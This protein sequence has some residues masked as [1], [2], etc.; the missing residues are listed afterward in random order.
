MWIQWQEPSIAKRT[1]FANRA[2]VPDFQSQ[3]GQEHAGP[4][5]CGGLRLRRDLNLR[6][7]E[8]RQNQDQKLVC[9]LRCAVSL[10]SRGVGRL[11]RVGAVPVSAPTIAV[12]SG[13]VS[14]D[15]KPRA[16]RVEAMPNLRYWFGS[17]CTMR[18][19]LD[20]SDNC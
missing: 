7:L 17:K 5:F 11:A 18:S 13:P 4:Q 10:P 16:F 12:S 14:V 8:S 2:G 9:G 15:L 3:S 19:T 6:D 20:R 1:Q